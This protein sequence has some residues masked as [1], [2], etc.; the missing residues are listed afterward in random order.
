MSSLHWLSHKMNEQL[1]SISIKF[2]NFLLFKIKLH[3]ED[4]KKVLEGVSH[5]LKVT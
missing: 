4:V 2:N 1:Y 3:L 5:Q